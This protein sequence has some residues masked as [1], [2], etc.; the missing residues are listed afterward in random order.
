MHLFT[1]NVEYDGVKVVARVGEWRSAAH[2]D[3]VPGLDR[4]RS[5]VVVGSGQCLAHAADGATVALERV[6]DS[7]RGRVGI[8]TAEL[9][10]CPVHAPVEMEPLFDLV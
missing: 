4:M 9:C 2:S 7:L 6:V 1:V 8:W 3:L 5:A 10:G